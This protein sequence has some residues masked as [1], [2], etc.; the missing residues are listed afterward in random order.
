M[1]RPE[2]K[3]KRKGKGKG[4][5]TGKPKVKPPVMSIAELIRLR[6]RSTP[7]EVGLANFFASQ[8]LRSHLRKAAARRKLLLAA[9]LSDVR[10]DKH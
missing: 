6:V 7:E 2:D 1:R 3:G 4:N 9:W 8:A 5:G 10:F